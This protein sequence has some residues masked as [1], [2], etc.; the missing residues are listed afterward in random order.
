MAMTTHTL[1]PLP[2]ATIVRPPSTTTAHA[3]NNDNS[4][5]PAQRMDGAMTMPHHQLNGWTVM[6]HVVITVHINPGEQYLTP[7]PVSFFH[8]R[9][10]GHVATGDVATDNEWLT[11][12]RW[13]EWIPFPSPF[14]T[15]EAGAMSLSVT[16]QK[17]RRTASQNLPPPSTMAHEWQQAPVNGNRWWRAEVS[18]VTSPHHWSLSHAI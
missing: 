7:L 3:N 10:R 16:Q 9:S 2:R 12:S 11:T 14:L 17:W 13:V 15:Q 8:T 18:K 1:S 5:S 6:T 4:M